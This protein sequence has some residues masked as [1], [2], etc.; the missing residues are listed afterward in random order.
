MLVPSRYTVCCRERLGHLSTEIGLA[1]DCGHCKEVHEPDAGIWRAPWCCVIPSWKTERRTA[2]ARRQRRPRCCRTSP[3]P[4][5]LTHPPA[6]DS[7]ASNSSR[8]LTTSPCFPTPL[9]W[10]SPAQEPGGHA[11]TT[12]N[13]SQK[14]ACESASPGSFREQLRGSNTRDT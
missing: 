14:A 12:Q 8:T 3:L 7:D 6:S 4:Q 5:K 9:C 2:R 1:H 10:T 13:A 11:Q